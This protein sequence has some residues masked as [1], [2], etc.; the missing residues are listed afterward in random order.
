MNRVCGTMDAS[1]KVQSIVP[2]SRFGC[3]TDDICFQIRFASGI[4]GQAGDLGKW[5]IKYIPDI[6]TDM[7]GI[8]IETQQ[9]NCDDCIKLSTK[10]MK[11]MVESISR[12]ILQNVG[13]FELCNGENYQTYR[14]VVQTFWEDEDGTLRRSVESYGTC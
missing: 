6:V 14:L 13:C 12:I 4:G 5:T 10:N 11:E 2:E 3:I 7:S 1:P 8:Q 9:E